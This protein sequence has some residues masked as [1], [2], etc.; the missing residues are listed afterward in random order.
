MRLH[1]STMEMSGSSA[2]RTQ[3]D[4]WTTLRQSNTESGKRCTALVMENVDCN[5]VSM[6]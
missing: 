1:N 4:R 5:F 2:R 6:R 3:Q